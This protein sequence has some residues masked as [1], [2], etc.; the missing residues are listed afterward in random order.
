[1]A[2]DR[3]MA[4]GFAGMDTMSR[5]MHERLPMLVSSEIVPD[6]GDWIQQEKPDRVS[7]ALLFP[8]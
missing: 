6:C 8:E 2:G 1:M 4:L 7:A 3:G 5:Q